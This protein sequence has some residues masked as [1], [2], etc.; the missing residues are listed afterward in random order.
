MREM[1]ERLSGERS[2]SMRRGTCEPGAAAAA[3]MAGLGLLED[4]GRLGGFDGEVEEA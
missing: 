4:G 1:A 2:R 3:A